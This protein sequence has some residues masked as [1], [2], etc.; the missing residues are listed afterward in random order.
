MSLH[1]ELIERY[2]P[3]LAVRVAQ[4]LALSVAWQI[5]TGKA[6]ENMTAG[7]YVALMGEDLVGWTVLTAPMGDYSGGEAVVC[8][9]N[10]DPAAPEI[11]IEVKHPIEGVMG[12]FEHELLVL[13]KAP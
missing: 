6:L 11:V 3:M 10:P 2:S 7:G 12:V 9:V 8:G 13:V 5:M 1:F 4:G